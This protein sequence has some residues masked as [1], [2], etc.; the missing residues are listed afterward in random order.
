MPSQAAV[1]A[2]VF[3]QTN[4]VWVG[5][6]VAARLLRRFRTYETAL[7]SKDKRMLLD[8]DQ[9]PFSTRMKHTVCELAWCLSKPSALLPSHA[10]SA[11]HAAAI[12]RFC[13]A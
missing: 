4:V 5:F 3:R 8:G 1:V 9:A 13:F 2:V 6:V 7:M 10:R 11:I 12:S